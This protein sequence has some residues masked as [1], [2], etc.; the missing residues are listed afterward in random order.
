MDHGHE[1]YRYAAVNNGPAG[2]ATTTMTVFY[3]SRGDKL[4]RVDARG[5][6]MVCGP[7]FFPLSIL[8]L[9]LLFGLSGGVYSMWNSG[10][11]RDG[12][13]RRGVIWFMLLIRTSGL[14]IASR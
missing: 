7:A 12:F 10:K 2:R 1:A 13:E 3:L 14:R 9:F 11:L 8:L 6:I 4:A 5:R